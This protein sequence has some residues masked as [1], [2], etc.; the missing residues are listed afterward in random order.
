MV[1]IAK[2]LENSLTDTPDLFSEQCIIENKSKYFAFLSSVIEVSLHL[3]KNYMSL[4]QCKH[5]SEIL[6]DS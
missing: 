4:H 1:F 6:K 3:G 5:L 2:N